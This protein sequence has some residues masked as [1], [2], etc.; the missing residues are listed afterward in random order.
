MPF[1]TSGQPVGIT[2]LDELRQVVRNSTTGQGALP[3]DKRLGY[4]M[5]GKIDDFVRNANHSTIA[6]PIP[7]NAQ[8]VPLPWQPGQSNA[9]AQQ[10]A[11]MLDQ[12]RNLWGRSAQIENITNRVTSATQRAATKDSG[13]NVA[14][15]IRQKLQPLI[16]PTRPNQMMRGLDPEA[17]AQLEKTIQ[18]SFWEDRLREVG[19][20]SP[21]R[22]GLHSLGAI[23]LAVSHP[24]S[25]PLMVG[26]EAARKAGD[27]YIHKNVDKLVGMIARG[28][29][30]GVLAGKQLQ[31][32]T[33]SNPQI[34]AY[35]NALRQTAARGVGMSQGQNMA[36]NPQPDSPPLGGF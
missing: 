16:D 15:T 33:A 14:N 3:N 22:G 19:K 35:V 23:G 28:G 13:K 26:A 1:L 25:I 5:L 27:S 31:A 11:T 18:P 12:A 30:V 17:Q 6:M 32:M 2:A 36:T 8:G 10:A 21:T 29:G 4:A 34:A 24:G 9:A 20:M 7:M